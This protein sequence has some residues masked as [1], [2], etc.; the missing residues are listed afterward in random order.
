MRRVDWSRSTRVRSANSAASAMRPGNARQSC[1][2]Y[3]VSSPNPVRMV[4]STSPVRRGSPHRCSA[5][6]PMKQNF[7]PRSRQNDW[8]SFARRKRSRI[9]DSGKHRL[10]LHQPGGGAHRTRE[11]RFERTIKC[12]D[13]VG[14]FDVAEF[15]PSQRRQPGA[16]DTPPFDEPAQ[17]AVKIARHERQCT[18][19]RSGPTTIRIVSRLERSSDAAAQ[20]DRSSFCRALVARSAVRTP[21]VTQQ[22]PRRGPARPSR[23]QRTASG[24]PRR[25]G[26][27]HRR[28]RTLRDSSVP[29]VVGACGHLLSAARAWTVQK[30]RCGVTLNSGSGCSLARNSRRAM[31]NPAPHLCTRLRTLIASASSGLRYATKLGCPKFSADTSP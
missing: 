5:K 12:I 23:W 30:T 26:R 4:R 16:G 14:H 3:A 6:P 19:F 10:L 25:R 20:R 11:R 31:G 28:S 21:H 2:I 27:R 24:P 22:R 8:M 29:V 17:F 1:S 15:G 7:Q 18:G 9:P 13:V